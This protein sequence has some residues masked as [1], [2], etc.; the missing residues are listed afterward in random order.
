M[1]ESLFAYIPCPII[2]GFLLDAACI[3]WGTNCGQRGNCWLYDSDYLRYVM[4]GLTLGAVVCATA[5][6][7]YVLY[8]C[9]S[10]AFFENPA[11]E[12]E[13]SAQS[14]SGEKENN[15]NAISVK[16]MPNHN[17]NVKY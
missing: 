11:E 7:A 2:Y 6:D 13:L 17:N 10:L 3:M 9:R 16:D 12:T 4:Q 1:M 8:L 14:P 15:D 5:L